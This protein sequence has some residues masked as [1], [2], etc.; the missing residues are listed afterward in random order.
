MK[1]NKSSCSLLPW[2]GLDVGFIPKSSVALKCSPS[3]WQADKI[4]QNLKQ[5]NTHKAPKI[6]IQLLQGEM[7]HSL[8]EW[9]NWVKREQIWEPEL[10]LLGQ[11]R[12]LEPSWMCMG[13]WKC[14]SW[15]MKTLLQEKSDST[16]FQLGNTLNFK[17]SLIP[18]W[19]QRTAFIRGPWA[20]PLLIILYLLQI[21]P[22][23]VIIADDTK[24]SKSRQKLEEVTRMAGDYLGADRG[25]YLGADRAH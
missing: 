24:D 25:D 15:S 4:Q 1:I 8:Q 11:R 2:K 23:V 6:K 14:L 3:A 12:I 17:M 22:I 10:H 13:R 19:S 21:I 18:R 7:V 16:D 20:S 5:T 9:R